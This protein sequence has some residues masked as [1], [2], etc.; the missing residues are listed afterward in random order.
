ML[1]RLMAGKKATK[2]MT[3]VEPENVVTRRSTDILAITDPEVA[4]AIAFIHQ[5]SCEPIHVADVVEAV[6]VS[7]STLEARFKALGPHDPRRDPAAA[8]RASPVSDRHHRS[9][10]QADCR[11]GRIRPRLLHDHD[12]SPAHGLDAGGISQTREIVAFRSAKVALL[13]QSERRQ[14]PTLASGRR[15]E[16]EI[17][18]EYR[19]PRQL[20][21][22]DALD[23][24]QVVMLWEA[25]FN[26]QATHNKPDSVIDKKIEVDDQSLL[27]RSMAVRSSAPSW[28]DTTATVDGFIPSQSLLHIVDKLRRLVAHAEHALARKG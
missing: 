8:S 1:D 6:H 22:L 15:K 10:D 7:R 18:P 2:L 27:L 13:S 3:L 4:A 23:R 17:M 28:P 26:Y 24:S 11:D 20:W 25:V 21:Y 9:A 12:L 16:M 19:I 5:H 14:S